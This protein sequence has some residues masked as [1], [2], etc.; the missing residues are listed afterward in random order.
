MESRKCDLHVAPS[1]LKWFYY[2]SRCVVQSRN[3]GRCRASIHRC[4]HLQRA[5]K[6]NRN[7][8]RNI[9][10]RSH[11]QN[12]TTWLVHCR[13]LYMF[14]CHDPNANRCN[15]H[16]CFRQSRNLARRKASLMLL[17]SSMWFFHYLALWLSDILPLCSE[18]K[19]N[20]SM[21][22]SQNR[23]GSSCFRTYANGENI[24]G[25]SSTLALGVSFAQTTVAFVAIEAHHFAFEKWRNKAVDESRW[26]TIAGTSAAACC[27][28]CCTVLSIA[29][30]V[31]RILKCWIKSFK[32][33]VQKFLIIFTAFAWGHK[34]H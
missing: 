17:R 31:A 5:R 27:W 24:N 25:P 16:N 19:R 28:R 26:R 20:S 34:R 18:G 33:S 21:I 4:F 8:F 22:H 1:P 6:R 32:F 9:R 15:V 12:H 7:C 30:F 14:R 23:N 13:S 10:R 29:I 3:R 2:C 11:F